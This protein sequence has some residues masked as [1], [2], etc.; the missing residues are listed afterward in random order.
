[1]IVA[2]AALLACGRDG[3]EA[4]PPTL[5]TAAER[6]TLGTVRDLGP[7]IVRGSLRRETAGPGITRASDQA[8]ELRWKDQDNWSWVLTRDGR[9][10]EETL[11]WD[12]VAWTRTGERA[13]ARKGDAEPYRV[14][15]ASV[16]DPWASLESFARQVVLTPGDVEDLEGRRVVRHVASLAPPPERPRRGWSVD[17]VEGTVWIDEATALR[18]QGDVTVSARDGDL[19]QTL[20]L[21]FSVTAIGSDPGLPTPPGAA[22]EPSKTASEGDEP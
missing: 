4:A 20:H 8:S 1:M 16:W 6:V 9:T 12:A 14:Q 17:A 21:A 5:T 22:P 11:V 2:L 19:R 10:V 13:F 3:E 18:L 7:C 15:L